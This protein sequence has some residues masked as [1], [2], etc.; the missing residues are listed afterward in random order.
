VFSGRS[1]PHIT[2][3][4]HNRTATPDKDRT[5]GERPAPLYPLMDRGKETHVVEQLPPQFRLVDFGLE[6]WQVLGRLRRF[7]LLSCHGRAAWP[8]CSCRGLSQAGPR[9]AHAGVPSAPHDLQAQEPLLHTL[10]YMNWADQ[11]SNDNT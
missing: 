7:R 1:E 9:E 4:T 6:F 10:K 8:A 2:N 3:C 5:L 11:C